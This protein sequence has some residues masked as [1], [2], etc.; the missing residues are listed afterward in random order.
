M[1][2]LEIP[3]YA[4][5]Y[6]MAKEADQIDMLE[7][8][9]SI[10]CAVLGDE[11][12]EIQFALQREWQKRGEHPGSQDIEAAQLAE[13]LRRLN[14]DARDEH[15]RTVRDLLAEFETLKGKVLA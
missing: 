15:G 1:T 2:T 5:G 3:T 6:D 7:I 13:A 10:I 8:R 12:M 14:L 4:G 11:R 9:W